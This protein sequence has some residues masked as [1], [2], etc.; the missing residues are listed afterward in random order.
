MRDSRPLISDLLIRDHVGAII[1][2]IQLI[3]HLIQVPGVQALPAL[4]ERVTAHLKFRELRLAEH[5]SLKAVEIMIEQIS[6][7]LLIRGL[8]QEILHQQ[9]L[10]RRG[11]NLRNKDLIIRID[12]WLIRIGITAVQGMSHFMRQREHIVQ[13]VIII[14]QH[15]RVRA[16]RTRGI[17]TAALALILIHVDPAIRKSL[18]KH[19]QI[20][21]AKGL[22][23]LQDRLLRLLERDLLR[24]A[25]DHGRINVIHVKLVQPQALLAKSHVAVKEL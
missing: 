25:L 4:A 22:Q 12:I 1:L 3:I 2:L 11:G 5:R 9:D 6:P 15:V 19:C 10:I 13:R 18:A 17:S 24:N 23:S 20:V 16:I 8:L 21:L 7:L 14:Q